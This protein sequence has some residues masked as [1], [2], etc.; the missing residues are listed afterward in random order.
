V[1][2]YYHF[3]TDGDDVSQVDI[4]TRCVNCGNERRAMALEID[5]GPTNQLIDRPLDPCEYPWLRAKQVKFS[6][7]WNQQDLE[8]FFPWI[9]RIQGVRA[10]LVTPFEAHSVLDEIE[11]L[12]KVRDEPLWDLYFYLDNT[13]ISD[14]SYVFWKNMP[15]VHIWGP[16]VLMERAGSATM[17][18]MEYAKEVIRGANVVPQP[19][20]F[21]D[22]TKT[23]INWLKTTYISERGKWTFDNPREYERF[24]IWQ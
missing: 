12:S 18:F 23:M 20:E 2:L 21:L 10:Y 19:G 6:A 1:S 22:F 5:Y 8:L 13:P 11:L 3:R 24:R 14:K 4:L 16:E 9:M 15:V 7:L 17:Y